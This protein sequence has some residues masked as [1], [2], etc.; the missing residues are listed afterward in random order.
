MHIHAHRS[1]RYLVQGHSCCHV[2]KVYSICHVHKVNAIWSK[3]RRY[4]APHWDSRASFVQKTY[5]TAKDIKCSKRKYGT[6]PTKE[7]LKPS[8]TLIIIDWDYQKC[9]TCHAH[10]SGLAR[11]VYIHRIW[12]YIWWFPC[13]LY[14]IYTVYTY[15]SGQPYACVLDHALPLP[16]SRPFMILLHHTWHMCLYFTHTYIHLHTCMHACTHTTLA[17]VRA[18]RAHQSLCCWY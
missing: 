2:M 9:K 11:A 6:V 1:A 18:C 3:V 10:V 8:D 17:C 12:P 13:Q 16:S 15:G 5:V 4:H 7:V 14:R